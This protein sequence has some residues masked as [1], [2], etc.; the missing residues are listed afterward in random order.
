MKFLSFLAV[1]L[2]LALAPLQA[3]A[4]DTRGGPKITKNEAEH[5]ALQRH[6][7]ARVSSARLETVKGR[8]V[9]LIELSQQEAAPNRMI[10]VDA[11]TGHIVSDK[12]SGR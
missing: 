9:W 2:I 8:K 1:S 4:R 3:D 5:I 12:K 7:G 10:S 6:R 11:V